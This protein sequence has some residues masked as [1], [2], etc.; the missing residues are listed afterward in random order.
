[1]E[2][3]QIIN[4]LEHIETRITACEP[5]ILEGTIYESKEELLDD[6][7]DFII[8]LED[9]NEEAVEYIDIH[10]LNGATFPLI[11][12]NNGWFDDYTVF[13]TEY[14]MAKK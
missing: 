1:M 13:A 14:E 3:L 4:I 8:E 10:F 2:L 5:L 11:A 9:G 12:K 6:I 7:N